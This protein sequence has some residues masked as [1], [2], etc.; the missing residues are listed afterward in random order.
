MGCW[1]DISRRARKNCARKRGSL[2]LRE[3]L[4]FGREWCT[5]ASFRR[6]TAVTNM[7]AIISTRP[8]EFLFVG[9]LLGLGLCQACASTP[10]ASAA[11]YDDTRFALRAGRIDV[12]RRRLPLTE[13]DAFI[14]LMERTYLALVQGKPEIDA[15]LEYSK[16][17][18]ER[19]RYKI[20]RELQFLFYVETPE[21]YYAS[22]HEIIWMHM[23]LSWG[24]S[25]RGEPD[26]ATIEAKKA[27]LLLEGKSRQ[28]HFDDPLLR[29]I[30]GVL[31]AMCGRW[32][33]ARVDFRVAARLDPSMKWAAQLASMDAPPAHLAL[34]LTGLGPEPHWDP[35]LQLNPLRGWRDLRFDLPRDDRRFT[36][37]DAKG[38]RLPVFVTPDA[39]P[40]YT[41]HLVRDHEIHNLI[42]DSRYGQLALFSTAKAGAKSVLGVVL[43]TTIVIL[44]IAAGGA[45]IYVAIEAG[46]GELAVVGAA[47][48]MAGSTW[49]IE[50]AGDIIDSSHRVSR[51]ELDLSGRYRFVRFLPD[52]ARVVFGAGLRPLR[53]TE[54]KQR[55]DL[56]AQVKGEV[57]VSIQYLP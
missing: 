53:L 17:I 3:G 29:T 22:E 55:T 40:W 9:I 7:I 27:A 26:R 34:I 5:V 21:G 50:L 41:R 49:G 16:K 32:E 46:S 44:S 35:K 52:R 4:A 43:G 12:A 23:L 6:S 25:L 10:L 45:V 2:F 38:R 51:Q 47:I 20:S 30:L 15:L 14:P 57:D 18:E 42:A 24:Y 39:S 11:D 13:G 48:A 19:V 37:T 8:K 31:W 33:D 56:E 1:R 54:G 28:G 36:V